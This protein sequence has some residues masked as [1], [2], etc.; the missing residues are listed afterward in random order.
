[1]G[2]KDLVPLQGR[3]MQ[4]TIQ[5]AKRSNGHAAQA[6]K[7]DPLRTGT[8]VIFPEPENQQ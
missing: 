5:R 8:D 2:F 7:R 4:G 1:L 3:E 6:G